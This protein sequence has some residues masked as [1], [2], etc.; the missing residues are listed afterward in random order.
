MR[1]CR[2]RGSVKAEE[3]ENVGLM[4]RSPVVFGAVMGIEEIGM[5]GELRLPGPVVL[6]AVMGIEKGG[7]EGAV[8]EEEDMV[9]RR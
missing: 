6:G 1:L 3:R 7:M 2:F 4:L 8:V 9:R 5:D